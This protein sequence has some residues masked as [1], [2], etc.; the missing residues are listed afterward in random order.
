MRLLSTCGITG[1]APEIAHR[2]RVRGYRARHIQTGRVRRAH[3]ASSRRE[4]WL[5]KGAP[6]IAIEVVSPTDTVDNIREKIA[7]YIRTAPVPSGSST[8]MPQWRS[9]PLPA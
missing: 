4:G 5:I 6:E 7:A 8:A 9:T 2:D 1:T 3:G